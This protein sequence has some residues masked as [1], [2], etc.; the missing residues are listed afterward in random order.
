LLEEVLSHRLKPVTRYTITSPAL[1]RTQ[2]ERVRREGI[3][4]ESEET[5][6][7]YMS[8]AVP[9]LGRR[10]ILAGAVSITAPTVRM[11]APR[12]T[13]ALRAAAAGITRTLQV[14]A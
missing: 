7:G 4:M 9:V 11:N 2:I 5:R 1:L 13:G 6:L 14:T 3:S 8:M 12:F 10:S